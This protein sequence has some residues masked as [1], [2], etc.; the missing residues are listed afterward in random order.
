MPR[1]IVTANHERTP[2][3]RYQSSPTWKTTRLSQPPLAN[4]CVAAM[5]HCGKMSKRSGAPEGPATLRP[6]RR[7][8]FFFEHRTP[9]WLADLVDER[10]HFSRRLLGEEADNVDH[11]EAERHP[12]QTAVDVV[13]V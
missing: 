3:R 2:R 4:A 11:Q 1:S 9:T 8:G 12:Q 10:L 13:Q 7:S 6:K 5:Y